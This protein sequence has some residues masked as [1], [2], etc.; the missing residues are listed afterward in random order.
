MT[1]GLPGM[2]VKPLDPSR[3]TTVC[4]LASL[5]MIFA[6]WA[7]SAGPADMARSIFVSV[8]S[9]VSFPMARLAGLDSA[10]LPNLVPVIVTT[11]IVATSATLFAVKRLMLPPCLN[12][13]PHLPVLGRVSAVSSLR[14]SLPETRCLFL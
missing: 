1:F 2:Q 13:V 4:P 12:V 8:V 3:K 5:S 9:L 7:I 6:D 11:A 10:R 14:G